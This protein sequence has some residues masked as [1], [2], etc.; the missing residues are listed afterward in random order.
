MTNVLWFVILSFACYRLAQLIADDDGPLS[1]FG[2]IRQWVDRRAKVE[3]ENETG[4]IWQSV[5]DG[6]N[7]H[8]CV[9]VWV[10]IPLGVVYSGIG[11]YTPIY[12]FAIAG[13]QS[14]LESR[15]K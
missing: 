9:G 7:C 11:W 12:I 4:L 10:A 1:I 14:W 3:Q 8:F 2:R 5:A 13:M 6:I 15:N